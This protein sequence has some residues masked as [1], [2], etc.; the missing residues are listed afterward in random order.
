MNFSKGTIRSS[1][2][3]GVFATVTE[4]VALVPN[5]ISE[6]ETKEIQRAL[7]VEVHKI[8]L[9]NSP[10]IGVLS[11]ALGRKV[12]VTS[13]CE[14]DEIRALE[15]AGLEVLQVNS[16][17]FNSIGNLICMNPH[18]GIASPLL[19]EKNTAEISRFLGIK[20]TTMKLADS[21]LAGSAVTVT[22][23]G[24]ICHPNISENDFEKLRHVFK[25]DGNATTANFGDL[26]VGNSVIANSKG[27]MA[28]EKTSGV[29]MLKI[30]EALRGD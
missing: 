19:S 21:E 7:E 9:G 24:F 13:L 30:D 4:D 3:V 29:E 1:P 5:N 25:V 8:K 22:N 14:H 11:K 20:I 16:G 17:G 6:K 10:L 2:Y 12:L 28:G 18:G 27:A 26:F 15:K 23:K